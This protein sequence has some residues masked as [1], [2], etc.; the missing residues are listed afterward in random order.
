MNRFHSLLST[1]M[2]LPAAFGQE[3]TDFGQDRTAIDWVLPGDF[4]TALARAKTEQRMLVIKGIS[5]GVDV[6]GS[7][8]ATKGVW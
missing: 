1:L 3:R 5:F 7:K 6:A 8:C 4:A 2:L